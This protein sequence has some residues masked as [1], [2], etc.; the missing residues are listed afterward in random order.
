MIKVNTLVVRITFSAYHAICY[1]AAL[2]NRSGCQ[3][4]ADG[5]PAAILVPAAFQLV[6]GNCA[7]PQKIFR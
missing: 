7:A 3:D 4:I 5:R 6:S 2:G 1:T